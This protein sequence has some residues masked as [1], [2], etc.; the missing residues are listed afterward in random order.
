MQTSGNRWIRLAATA[1]VIVGSGLVSSAAASAEEPGAADPPSDSPVLE[2]PATFDD[3]VVIELLVEASPE[4]HGPGSDPPLDDAQAPADEPTPSEAD[5]TAATEAEMDAPL[6]T[7]RDPVVDRVVAPADGHEE[8]SE[9]EE[10]QHGAGS[11]THEGGSSDTHGGGSSDSHEGGSSD[12]HGGGGSDS[13]EGGSQTGNPYRMTFAVLW[14]TAAGDPIVELLPA[15]RTAFEL[16]ANSTTG[17]GKPT[18]AICT[19]PDSSTELVCTFSNRGGHAAIDDGMVV[20]ARPTARY[21]VIVS[22]A[23]D[24][25]DVVN[26]NG[27]PYSARDLC[28]RGGDGH[29]GGSHLAEG[30]DESGHDGGAGDHVFYCEHTVEMHQL[31]IV[32]PPTDQES[33]P[34]SAPAEP[35]PVL[36]EASTPAPAAVVVAS[37]TP[38]TLPATGTSMSLILTIGGLLIAGGAALTAATRVRAV[39]D[40]VDH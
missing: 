28:P 29:S 38:R 7:D 22:D 2:S 23:P 3:T 19:Y 17:S 35:A 24:G 1:A 10:P 8:A 12:T 37:A 31:A 27:G 33:Q 4:L 11:D 20:P 21:T 6:L 18:T 25:W 32:V 26:A 39:G 36:P 14:Y 40:G 16:A 15:W 30:T 34:P 13:H 9:P 5:G